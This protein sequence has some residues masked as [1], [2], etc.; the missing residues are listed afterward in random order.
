MYFISCY[1][2]LIAFIYAN[3]LCRTT[4][5]LHG[6]G[7]E[8]GIRCGTENVLLLA[9]LKM[10]SD[11]AQNETRRLC[12]YMLQC[13]LLFITKLRAA[14]SHQEVV[15]LIRYNGPNRHYQLSQA[16]PAGVRARPISTRVEIAMA[17]TVSIAVA[18]AMAIVVK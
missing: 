11:I 18:M 13:K 2:S 12:I 3:L 4:P 1:F 6:G 17:M 8:M 15:N 9:G 7:Q 5:L 16:M 14:M 10:A